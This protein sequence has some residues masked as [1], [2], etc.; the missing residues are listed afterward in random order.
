[1]ASFSSM[2]YVSVAKID[3][4]L[5]LTGAKAANPLA[6]GQTVAAYGCFDD[7]SETDLGIF[8]IL[9]C[10]GKS[11]TYDMAPLGCVDPYWGEH[12]R[13]APSVTAKLM[14]RPG[15]KTVEGV[16]LLTRWRIIS[17]AGT[18]PEAGELTV[19]GKGGA[20]DATK[21]WHFLADYVVT[22]AEAR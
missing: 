2:P 4:T 6:A 15:E 10:S 7:G 22:E 20:E 11:H 13:S 8:K 18:P 12:L 19:L 17:E 9:R 14:T 3:G 16:E 21:K 5:Q 1:M